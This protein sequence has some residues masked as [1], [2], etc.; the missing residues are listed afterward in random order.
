MKR[1][2]LGCGAPTEYS[3]KKPIFCANCGNSFE[4]NS[5]ASQVIVKKVEFQK[6][7][8]V[9][10]VNFKEAELE[11][12]TDDTDYND[13]EEITKVPN[14]SKLQIETPLEKPVRGVKLKDLM[15]TAT[16]EN[17]KKERRKEK[18]KRVGKKQ[19]LEDFAKEAGSLRKNKR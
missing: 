19:T 10:K 3:L 5:Q 12:D 16:N 14:I 7:T 4:N 8:I 15:G 1:Y 11:Y 13:G 9:K 17:S 6:P 2:C 18:T